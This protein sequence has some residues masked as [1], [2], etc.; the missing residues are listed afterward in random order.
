[1]DAA[2]FIGKSPGF[3]KLAHQSL[4]RADVLIIGKDRAY[5]LHT[6]APV[7]RDYPAVLFTLAFQATVVH[8]LPDPPIWGSHLEGIIIIAY[9]GNFSTKIC[10]S[11][12]CRFFPADPSQLNLDTKLFCKQLSHL[13]FSLRQNTEI[14]RHTAEFSVR[15]AARSCFRF[16]MSLFNPYMLPPFPAA[17]RRQDIFAYIF[18]IC[19]NIH[20]G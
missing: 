18:V 17:K 1:M 15:Y 10:G 14:L 13:L 12:F 4:H 20:S 11:G 2:G 8:K 7:G 6:V 3:P 16:L 9:A 5:H 19:G